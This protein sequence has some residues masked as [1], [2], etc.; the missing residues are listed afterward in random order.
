METKTASAFSVLK[1][2]EVQYLQNILAKG[3]PDPEDYPVFEEYM[4]TLSDE[5]IE[6]ARTLLKPILNEDN[7]I[8]F[9]FVKPY[10]YAGDF[11]VIDMIY[12]VKTSSDPRYYKWD[13]W[14]HMQHAPRAVRNRKDFFLKLCAELEAKNDKPKE[15]LI[16]GSGPAASARH[17]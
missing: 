3:G 11:H 1:E 12:Q 13:K 10:G 8:G 2:N 4:N 15:M 14:Y 17:R 5:G 6:E 16:L 9:G 7:M